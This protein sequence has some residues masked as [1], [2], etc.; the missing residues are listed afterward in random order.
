M[1]TKRPNRNQKSATRS[2]RSMNHYASPESKKGELSLSRVSVKV[3][4][5]K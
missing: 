1:P 5:K 2:G 4:V 3:S